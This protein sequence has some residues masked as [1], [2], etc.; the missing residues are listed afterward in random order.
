M[1]KTSKSFSQERARTKRGKHWRMLGRVTWKLV[2]LA[3]VVTKL[4]ELGFAIAKW[5]RE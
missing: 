3:R 4:V 1:S 2:V 5:L